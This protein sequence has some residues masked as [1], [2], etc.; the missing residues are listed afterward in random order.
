MI[1]GEAVI[2]FGVYHVSWVDGRMGPRLAA[3][4]GVIADAG[5]NL[6]HPT[7]DPT[8]IA[9]RM[10]EDAAGRGLLVVGEIYWKDRASIVGRFRD[11]P[12]IIAWDI[13]DD[14]NWPPDE[15]EITPAELRRRRDEFR[16]L[17]PDGLT[18]A[19]GIGAPSLELGDYATALDLLGVQSYPIGN[20]PDDPT[21][22]ERALEEHVS[23]MRHAEEEAAGTGVCLIANLQTFSWEGQRRPTPEELRNMLYAALMHGFRGVM[24]YTYYDG[25]GVLP[26]TDP[27]LWRELRKLRREVEAI[28]S[29]LLDGRRADLVTD[30]NR[31][32]AAL[33]HE[34]AVLL[35]TVLSTRRDET[36]PV[37]IELPDAPE[38]SAVNP[39]FPGRPS[40]LTLSGGKLIGEVGPGEVHVYRVILPQ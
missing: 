16:Q 39:A 35:V 18:Y 25:S 7:L 11:S 40:G 10:M 23:N 21:W 32:H 3:D 9:D 4:L 13:A 33:W 8:P 19:S 14:V 2:P 38:G 27:Q 12:A 17:D 37:A 5:F 22:D 6:V 30:R 28:E 26:E 36:V 1:D 15:P 24:T 20:S 34:D 29:T 31:I